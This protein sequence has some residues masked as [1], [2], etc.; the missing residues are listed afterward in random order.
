ML[1]FGY[2]VTLLCVTLNNTALSLFCCGLMRAKYPR[3]HV[4]IFTVMV[5]AILL[6]LDLAG[7]AEIGI[8]NSVRTL[9][10][11]VIMTSATILLFEGRL[12]KKLFV[13]AFGMIIE[14]CVQ[15][16]V[17]LPMVLNGFVRYEG[18]HMELNMDFTLMQV[19]TFLSNAAVLFLIATVIRKGPFLIRFG[20]VR[21]LA[22]FLI[23][24]ALLFNQFVMKAYGDHSFGTFLEWILLIF[25]CILADIAAFYILREMD[26]KAELEAAAD[27]YKTQLSMQVSL[28]ESFSAYGENLIE[29][30]NVVVQT[31]SQVQTS[32]KKQSYSDAEN[33]L[34]P[35]AEELEHLRT[36][37]YCRHR[38][39]N[40]LIF[41]KHREMK[42]SGISLV[43]RI[44]LEKD[45]FVENSDLCRI[46]SNLLDNAIEACREI[47]DAEI[48]LTCM[49]VKHTLLIK[50]E[51]PV[52]DVIRFH[53]S[54]LPLSSKEGLGHGRGLASVK[55]IAGKYHGTLK[56][57]A[58]T[59]KFTVS[60]N[61][62]SIRMKGGKDSCCMD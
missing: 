61:L 13:L 62:F 49:P 18:N 23:T 46:L 19:T 3:T 55:E 36:V 6:P 47:P 57:E 41:M 17:A 29:I 5:P 33:L 30:K 28:Y 37:S 14:S 52:S 20:T 7:I 38:I 48:R 24:Q 15:S 26:K 58:D 16:L 9:C 43:Y 59:D 50:T 53:K 12:T 2:V 44:H 39:V 35:L 8:G 21:P 60:V 40:A 1:I 54:G 22:L 31:L 27:F 25:C 51:N 56:I 32:L 45:C 11:V 10:S 42:Q 4:L 34:E